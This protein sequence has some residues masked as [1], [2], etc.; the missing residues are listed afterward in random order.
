MG[1]V[2]HA[3]LR[4]PNADIEMQLA[5]IDAS[6]DPHFAVRCPTLLMHVHDRQLFGLHG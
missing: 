3:L 4:G 5:H 1:V 2:R 6:I